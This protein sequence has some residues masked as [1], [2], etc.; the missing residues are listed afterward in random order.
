MSS[1]DEQRLEEI[2]KVNVKEPKVCK[3]CGVTY[4]NGYMWHCQRY[5][6]HRHHVD[7]YYCVKCMPT[8]EAVLNEIDTDEVP[9]GLVG[10]DEYSTNFKKDFTRL[11]AEKSKEKKKK[12]KK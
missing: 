10:V 6:K 8:E 2:T 12:K 4:K 11:N 5:G 7:Y 1:I 9:Y 3:C